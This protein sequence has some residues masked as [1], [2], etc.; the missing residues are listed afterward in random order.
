MPRGDKSAYST[1]QKRKAQRIEQGYEARGVSA[2]E[3]AA[4]AWA[5]VNKQEGGGNRSGSGRGKSASSKRAARKDSA[6]R[7]VATKRGHS[8]NQGRSRRSATRR[9][10]A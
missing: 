1:K 5:T 10:S 8:P 6:R 3:A 7:A 2:K 4:R 9:R